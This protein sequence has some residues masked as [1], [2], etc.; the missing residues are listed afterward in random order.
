MLYAKKQKIR[1][2][3]MIFILLNVQ[4]NPHGCLYIAAY[5]LNIFEKY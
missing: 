2:V 1:Q 4:N 3:N 5:V